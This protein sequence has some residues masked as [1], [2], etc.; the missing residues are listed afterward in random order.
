MTPSPAPAPPSPK[1]CSLAEQR[2]QERGKEERGAASCWGDGDGSVPR[3]GERPVRGK[4]PRNCFQRTQARGWEPCA[5]EPPA[6]HGTGVHPLQPPP[7]RKGAHK[8]PSV[9]KKHHFSLGPSVHG[10]EW[11]GPGR[12]RSPAPHLSPGSGGGGE[13]GQG[14]R[15]QGHEVS[16][17]ILPA[18]AAFLGC[19]E[20]AGGGGEGAGGGV[21]RPRS[22]SPGRGEEIRVH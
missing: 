9:E 17:G 22:R 16:V 14:L 8:P 6:L 7:E 11:G 1:R 18:G 15:P 2:G 13:C 3:R 10:A 5:S 19:P 20:R 21:E 4:R 12:R